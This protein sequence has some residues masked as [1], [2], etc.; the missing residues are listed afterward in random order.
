[1]CSHISNRYKINTGGFAKH[2]TMQD[3]VY[4]SCFALYMQPCRLH[5]KFDIT[6]WV[7]SAGITAMSYLCHPS[8]QPFLAS[9]EKEFF[10][11]FSKW[12]KKI[13][14]FFSCVTHSNGRSIETL[15]LNLCNSQFN[16]FTAILN[17]NSCSNYR[18]L[19]NLI[20]MYSFGFT[21]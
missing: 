13:V 2:I 18:T 17:H 10:K 15:T 14:T 9:V 4:N 16:P 8:G 3:S 11:A 1:M 19:M 20:S 21:L 12:P 6:W 7:T 5:M